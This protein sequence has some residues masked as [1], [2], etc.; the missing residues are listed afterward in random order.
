MDE[1]VLTAA[2]APSHAGPLSEP[3]H[4]DRRHLLGLEGMS[5]AAVLEIL[6]DAGRFRT[7]W[8]ADKKP[9]T[10]LRGVEVCNAFFEDSTRTRVSFE[11]SERRLGATRLA[12][13]VSGSSLSKG[14]TF[15]DTLRTLESMGVD[16]LVIRHRS[17]GAAAYA[18]RQA[19][20]SVINAGDGRHEHPTQ[21]LL[22][23]MT[24]RDAW[25]GEFEGRRIAIVGDVAHSRVAR[26]NV[27]ALRALGA[28]VTLGGPATLVPAGVDRWG[29]AV[30]DTVEDAMSGADAV[31]VLRIQHERMDQGLVPSLVEYAR[32]WKITA[33][34]VRLMR[35]DAVVMHPGPMNRGIEIAPDVADGGRSVIF[36]QVE[37]GVAVRC[38]V[39]A[40][41][42][43]ARRA[44]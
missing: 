10:E 4:E 22:D 39:L 5:R 17:S 20:M 32:T 37:N 41:C 12:F 21:G 25:G 15:L 13:G 16:I 40:R 26:S 28:V 3:V 2:P 35:P 33:E 6:D 36:H 43:A 8:L 19:G 7:R 11:I 44:A 9:G 30:A 42:A 24:L 14:E 38:A 18:A 31:M 29:C 1:S 27:H 23:V 34:R